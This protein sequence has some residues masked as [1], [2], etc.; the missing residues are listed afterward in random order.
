MPFVDEVL[1]EMQ[2]PAAQQA[3]RALPANVVEALERRGKISAEAA[4]K[5]AKLQE[6][7]TELS[8]LRSYVPGW[9]KFTSSWDGEKNADGSEKGNGI[10]HELATLR[11]RANRE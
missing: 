11:Q 3:L 6:V 7:E 2:D 1:A 10:K 5:A 8:T 9:Q 4:E